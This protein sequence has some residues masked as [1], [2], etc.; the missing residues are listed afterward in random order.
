MRDTP[1]VICQ[2]LGTHAALGS[3]AWGSGANTD[4][5]WSLGGRATSLG[6]TLALSLCTWPTAPSPGPASLG[7]G[8]SPCPALRVPG[9]ECLAPHGLWHSVLAGIPGG[10]CPHLLLTCSSLSLISSPG[11]GPRA[12]PSLR[13]NREQE[14]ELQSCVEDAPRQVCPVCVSFPRPRT[15]VVW[16]LLVFVASWTSEVPTGHCQSGRRGGPV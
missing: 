5:R 14:S 4:P 6:G 16:V 2:P 15:R 3:P 12:C 7:G 8:A 10:M 1:S 11:P 9:A 13:F